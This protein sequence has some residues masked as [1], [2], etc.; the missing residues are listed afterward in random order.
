MGFP[1]EAALQ[2]FCDF[3]EEVVIAINTSEDGTYEHVL[4]WKRLNSVDKLVIVRTDFSYSDPEFDGKIKNAALQA[5][6]QDYCILLDMDEEIPTP[7]ENRPKWEKAAKSLEAYKA[8]CVLIPS[9][10]LCGDKYHYKDIGYKFYLHKNH[11]GLQRGVA[12]FARTEDGKIDIKKSDTTELIYPN[13]RLASSYA[14]YN[15]IGSLR[16]KGIPYVFH[17]WGVNPEQRVRQN[18]F[19]KP[20]WENR[21]GKNVDDIV[22]SSDLIKN[23]EIFAHNLP[24]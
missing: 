6:T 15:D 8:D 16:N 1:W 11:I 13:G 7:K 14:Y 3:S 19:W 23:T 5:C 17:Y 10:N 12:G 24:V 22:L 20:V 21:A 2:N 9:V 4:D 18:A